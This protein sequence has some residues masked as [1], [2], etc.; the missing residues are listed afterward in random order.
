MK[1]RGRRK[2]SSVE[3]LP[4]NPVYN[5]ALPISQATKSDLL[6]R[7]RSLSFMES[8]TLDMPTSRAQIHRQI[9]HHNLQLMTLTRSRQYELEWKQKI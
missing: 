9:M 6:E 4:L 8:V 7:A 1:L 2:H 3:E 5:K